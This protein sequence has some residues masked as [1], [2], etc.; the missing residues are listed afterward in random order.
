MNFPSP[1]PGREELH[2]LTQQEL[3]EALQEREHQL[4]EAQ[5]LAHLGS[6]TWDLATGELTWSDELFRICGLTPQGFTPTYEQFLARIHGDH[7]VRVE[8]IIQDALRTKTAFDYESPILVE[9]GRRR[10]IHGRG[11]VVTDGVGVA[12]RMHGTAQDITDRVAIEES[13]A[14][15]E[16]RLAALTGAVSEVVFLYEP[17]GTLRFSTTRLEE[18]L[19]YPTGSLGGDPWELVHPEDVPRVQGEITQLQEEAGSTT[20][21]EFR[22]RHSDGSWRTMEVRGRNAND[23][24][25][26]QGT[27]LTTRDITDTKAALIALAKHALADPLTGLATRSELA[28][29]AERALARAE[30]KG[31]VT[32]IL[33]IDL[34]R[35][36]LVND[37]F[38]HEAGDRV[39]VE[40]A[41]RLSQVFR[42][43]DA[44]VRSYDTVARLGGDEFLVLCEQVADVSVAHELAQRVGEALAGA[45]ALPVGEVVVTAAVGV[46]M[47]EPPEADVDRLVRQAE[48]AMHQAKRRGLGTWA[49][50]TQGE[51]ED[52]GAS[53]AEIAS[54]LRRALEEH[55][56][57]LEYQPRLALDTGRITGAEALLRWDH[58]DRGT[59]SPLDFIPQ[60]EQTGLIVPIGAWVIG[61]ACRQTA[62]WCASSPGRPPLVTSVNVSAHQFGPDLIGVVAGALTAAELDPAALCLEVTETVLMTDVAAAVSTVRELADLGVGISIDDFGTGYS[63]LAYLKRLPLDELKIDKSFVDGLGIEAD[64]TAIV[65]TVIAMAQA[66]GLRVVAEG[67]ETGGQVERLRTLGCE[68]VQGYY[69][70]RP[71]PPESMDDLLAVEAAATWRSHAA[72]DAVESDTSNYR[73]ERILVIDDTADVRMLAR[74]SLAAVGFDVHEAG[75]GAEGLAAALEIVP[76]CVLLDLVMPDMGGFEVCRALRADRATAECTI[77]MLTSNADAQD[78]IRAFECG[79]DDYIIKPFSPRDLVSRVRA[80]LG[81]RRGAE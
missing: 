31:S 16:R 81:R 74:M 30:R 63:S 8:R 52:A 78:K 11:N 34:D 26:I 27:I 37:T 72:P 80:A 32:A 68:E 48:A 76:D 21:F 13:L 71:G 64:D 23:D 54:E 22:A 59:V 19:G 46:A 17:D 75:S 42:P 61:E 36:Q 5:R 14:A 40:V 38:G 66:L 58:P 9:D 41:R 47:A 49:V 3:F 55:Q 65:A 44:V 39:L 50:F 7:R 79:A 69:Y 4:A 62:A 51:G 35:F 45:I 56:F 2:V 29:R 10:V 20:T 60:A 43:Y 57:R 15:S 70:A 18:S 12:V 1:R 77:L 33:A 67:V 24:R 28:D 53:T 73:P 6:W 25:D